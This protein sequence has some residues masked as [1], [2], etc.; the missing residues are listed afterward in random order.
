MEV[1]QFMRIL[2]RRGWIIAIVV[3]LSSVTSWVYSSYFADPVYEA[4]NKLIVNK[5]NLDDTGN[6]SLD[7]NVINTNIMLINS[8]K[9]ILYSEAI[10]SKVLEKHPDITLST[11]DLGRK[12]NVVTAQN[13]QIV[14]LQVKDGVYE[15]AATLVNSIA[16]VFQQEVP[17]IMKINNV[18]ILDKAKK[19]ITASPI[20][21]VVSLNIALTFMVSLMASIGLVF[22]LERLDESIKQEA[23]VERYLELSTLGVIPKIE[24]SD[25]RIQAKE[26]IKKQEGEHYVTVN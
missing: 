19:D 10:L 9:E 3:I 23:D 16:E 4:S 18:M 26:K 17:K 5:S 15:R 22:I 13:S 25:L 20:S 11:T 12:L 1:K 24:K 7:I 14:T 8:Y 21:P 2:L 6:P